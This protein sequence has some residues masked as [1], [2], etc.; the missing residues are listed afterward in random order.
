MP[1][2]I[3][4]DPV[5]ICA[6]T[7]SPLGAFQGAFTGVPATGRVLPRSVGRWRRPG[8]RARMWTRS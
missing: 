6:A 7:R 4:S 5:M 2:D 8:S 1:K 3:T